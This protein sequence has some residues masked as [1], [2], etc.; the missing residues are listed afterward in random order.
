M[1]SKFIVRLVV[2][3]FVFSFDYIFNIYQFRSSAA[4]AKSKLNKYQFS[5]D[6]EEGVEDGMMICILLRK[7]KIFKIER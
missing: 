3:F 7:K 2:C 5:L 1:E 4:V 6:N